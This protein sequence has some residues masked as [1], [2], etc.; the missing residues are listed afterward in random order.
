MKRNKDTLYRPSNKFIIDNIM[1]N[2]RA[3]TLFV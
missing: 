2:Q 1:M 3:Y